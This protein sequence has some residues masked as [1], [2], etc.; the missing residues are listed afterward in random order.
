MANAIEPAVSP[1]ARRYIEKMLRFL[2]PSAGKL[3][4]QFRA[5]LIKRSAAEQAS[6]R[7]SSLQTPQWEREARIRALMAITPAAASRLRTLARFLEQVAYNGRRLAK[8]NVPPEEA[9]AALEEFGALL[10]PVFGDDFQPAREQLRLA[11]TLT[12]NDAYYE[13]R[14]AEA[15]TFFRLYRAET[16]SASLEDALRGFVHALSRAVRARAGRLV[17]R[18]G[19]GLAQPLY[20]ERG[21]ANERLISSGLA[22]GRYASYWSYPVGETAAVQFAFSTK[23]PWLP[24]EISLVA[25]AAGRCAAALNRARLENAVRRLHAEAKRAEED[26]RRRIGRE[27]H[28]E[29]GQ[30]LLSLRLQLETIER[31]APAPIAARLAEARRTTEG[32]IVEIRRA[33]SALS[34][35]SLER[36][37]LRPALRRLA[38]RF[39]RTHPCALRLS[40]PPACDRIPR[41]QAETVYR[42]AQECLQNIA[43]HSGAGVVKVSLRAADSRIRLSVADNGAG[44]RL[45]KAR[46]KPMAFGLESMRERAALMSGTLAIRT[47][48]GRGTRVV[49]DL[50]NQVGE[51]THHVENPNLA[52]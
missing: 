8:L 16:E 27:L 49:L 42:V 48:P 12:L 11:T 40:A 43:K 20:I 14:D 37:G 6:S 44:F 24:R 34:P 41:P 10:A 51:V 19:R 9:A 33:V 3:D 1:T 4:S 30:S 22:R 23:Y 2:A 17:L 50:P 25:A 18:E 28:D 35:L 32:A 31:D 13:V 7:A 5:L 38:E 15:Q 47:A 26:E 36:L 52:H 21:S 45:E 39:E 46:E 29:T